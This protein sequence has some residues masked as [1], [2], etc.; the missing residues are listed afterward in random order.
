M[1]LFEEDKV[2]EDGE[3][4]LVAIQDRGRDGFFDE[5]DG[6]VLDVAGQVH[7]GVE[8]EDFVGVGSRQGFRGHE[9][10][11]ERLEVMVLH[12]HVD[13]LIGER[14]G[15]REVERHTGWG[16][17]EVQHAGQLRDQPSARHAA[18]LLHR[19]QAFLRLLG[20]E[21][22]HHLP[23]EQL[24]EVG[25]DLLVALGRG[26]GQREEAPGDVA[27]QRAQMIAAGAYYKRRVEDDGRDDVAIA[28]V[29]HGGVG[30]VPVGVGLRRE[31]RESAFQ[32]QSGLL[33]ERLSTDGVGR[34]MFF[35]VVKV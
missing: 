20:V 18:R 35:R 23:G 19:A 29:E 26:E 24:L 27:R 14:D 7:G 3:D 2:G 5:P 28:R 31:L 16:R 1:E 11:Q 12:D 17:P 25:Q 32:A 8:V 21:G 4:V 6:E 34:T 33:D 13:G 15:G 30:E 22:L 9:R 10:V